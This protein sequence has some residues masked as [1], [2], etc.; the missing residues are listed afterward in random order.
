MEAYRVIGRFAHVGFGELVAISRE[1]LKARAHNVDVQQVGD[2]EDSE[3]A[4]LVVPRAV[5]EFKQGEMIGLSDVPKSQAAAL[6]ALKPKK[7]QKDDA[8]A[9][10]AKS[11]YRLRGHMEDAELRRMEEQDATSKAVEKAETA[12]VTAWTNEWRADATI[13]A[14]YPKVEDYIALRKSEVARDSAN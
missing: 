12:A 8:A 4:V 9:A 11:V 3:A 5:M 14:K 6:E 2:K 1:Q 10:F 13:S 7:G